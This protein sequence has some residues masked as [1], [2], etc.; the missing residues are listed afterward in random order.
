MYGRGALYATR[1]VL[2]SDDLDDNLVQSEAVAS[3]S[4]FCF[5]ESALGN[6][7]GTARDSLD[8]L[9]E[10]QTFQGYW[11]QTDALLRLLGIDG[12]AVKKASAKNLGAAAG[13]DHVLATA[14][15][16]V[17][18]RKHKEADRD[19]WEMLV[20]KAIAWLEAQGL[21]TAETLIATAATLL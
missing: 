3:G 12:D 4:E 1:G 15:V 2:F 16:I 13:N 6:E 21:G 5:A 17:F 8:A 10:W 7:G 14:A 18:L 9:V 19:D 11:Q 20:E